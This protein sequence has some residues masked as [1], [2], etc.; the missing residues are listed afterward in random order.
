MCWTVNWKSIKTTAICVR[1]KR[2]QQKEIRIFAKFAKANTEKTDY[3]TNNTTGF[4]F[5]A[6]TK[7]FLNREIGAE[8]KKSEKLNRSVHIIVYSKEIIVRFHFGS[9][10]VWQQSLPKLFEVEVGCVRFLSFLSSWFCYVCGWDIITRVCGH[11]FERP[12]TS[13][14]KSITLKQH[15]TQT[16]F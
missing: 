11:T 9:L 4:W 3:W 2:H 7:E 13:A 8:W 15:K 12:Y 6:E 10:C 1:A 5:R 14:H 16:K